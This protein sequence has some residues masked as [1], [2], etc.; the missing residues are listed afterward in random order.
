MTGV[1]LPA[2]P[3]ISP[4]GFGVPGLRRFGFRDEVQSWRPGV[5][6]AWSSRPQLYGVRLGFRVLGRPQESIVWDHCL[7]ALTLV[8]NIRTK[9]KESSDWCVYCQ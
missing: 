7:V 3:R 9:I 6:G 1:N 8:G 5:L 2:R 4:V